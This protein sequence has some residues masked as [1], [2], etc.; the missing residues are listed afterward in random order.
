MIFTE[1]R[2]L[3]DL[4]Y[5]Q[6]VF[7]Q[8]G[9]IYAD[10]LNYL[11]DL[12]CTPEQVLQNIGARTRKHIRHAMRKGKVQIELITMRSQLAVWYELVR[13][14]YRDA[15]VPLA[16]RSLFEAAFD[17]LQ[18]KGMVQYWLGRVGSEYVAASA[19]LCYKDVIY[20]W[21]SGLDRNYAVELPGEILMWHVLSWGSENGY[22][23]YDFGGAG[24][25]GEAYGVRD[26]KAKFGGQLVCYG[27]NNF[28]HSPTLL[29]FS[30][31]GYKVYRQL[32]G[33]F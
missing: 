23:T 33:W 11:I 5:L 27:R 1:L 6:G 2:N 29:R 12:N 31:M 4:T 24:K 16:D 28:V 32:I 10:H 14:T 18:P 8:Y 25:P 30:E 9:F 17:V 3:T 22:K 21:Y 13:K 20:G 19:E 26:F 15:R 7:E